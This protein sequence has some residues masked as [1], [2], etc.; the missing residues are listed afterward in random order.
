MVQCTSTCMVKLRRLRYESLYLVWEATLQGGALHYNIFEDG[1]I[2]AT[3]HRIHCGREAKTLFA[4]LHCISIK[5]VKDEEAG[6]HLI[7]CVGG[8]NPL[9]RTAL[10]VYI[11][12]L[13]VTV[14]SA[15][16]LV[17]VWKAKGRTLQTN[18]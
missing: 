14:C 1:G 7:S 3:S 12:R 17:V 15:T 11:W 9:H 13:R 10:H 8:F 5:V 2:E 16:A 18:L 4:V 6:S